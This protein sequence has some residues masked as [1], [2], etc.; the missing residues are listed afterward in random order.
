MGASNQIFN[1]FGMVSGV[2]CKKSCLGSEE[3]HS[4]FVLGFFSEHFM[5]Y[6]AKKHA[7]AKD[8]VCMLRGPICGDLRRP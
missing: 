1:D 4:M 7:L 5:E 3:L 8:D 2:H 6:I